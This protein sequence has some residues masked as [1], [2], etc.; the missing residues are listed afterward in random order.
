MA[1]VYSYHGQI[2]S[3][4]MKSPCCKHEIVIQTDPQNCEYVI[5]SGAQK[6]VE[7]YDVEDAETM[8]LTAEEG[9][10]FYLLLQ[11]CFLEAL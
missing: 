3:F 6:K 2:W 11:V 4:A 9:W 5:T 8:E 1:E 10:V 7:E